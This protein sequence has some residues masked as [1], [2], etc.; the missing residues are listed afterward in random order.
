MAAVQSHIATLAAAIAENTQRIDKYLE[1][2]DLPHPGFDADAP[3]DLGL[4]PE[5]EQARVAVLQATQELNDLLQGPRE[6]LFN[7]HVRIAYKLIC[8][9]NWD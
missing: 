4:P 5:L 3:A 8:P 7:H 6:L 2:N 1:D 9:G